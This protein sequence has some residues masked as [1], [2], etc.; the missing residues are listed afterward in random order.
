MR[1]IAC[2]LDGTIVCPDGTISVRTL[3]ALRACEQA[4]VHVVFVTGRP[5]RWMAPVAEAT[6]GAGHAI[7]G[8]GAVVIDLSTGAVVEAHPLRVDVVLRSPTGCAPGCPVRVL[9][10]ETTDNYRREPGFLPRH[11]VARMAPTG[12]LPSLLADRPVVLKVLCR[13]EG[14][15]ADEML[16][17][18]R[19]AL[20]GLAEPVHSNP[21]GDMLEISALGVSKASALARLAARRGVP[22]EAVVAFGDMPNDVP[23]LRWAGRGYAMTGGHPEAV[24]AAAE[25]APPC[26][27]DG[28][29]QVL[30][31]LLSLRG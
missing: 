19:A 15:S 23:M 14:G 9:A 18:A 24:A 2:D 6:G 5:P 20:D 3:A 28:V 16:A 22:A 10:I 12:S 1:L 26:E 8:N 13:V 11:E 27:S 17:V 25:L 7:C 4:G 29:A 30:E 31:H 21:N